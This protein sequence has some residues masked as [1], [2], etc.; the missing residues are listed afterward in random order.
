MSWT[1]DVSGSIPNAMLEWFDGLTINKKTY[2]II[3]T[4]QRRVTPAELLTDC[5]DTVAD[6]LSEESGVR[7]PGWPRPTDLDD[8]A[9]D[10]VFGALNKVGLDLI[11]PRFL[12]V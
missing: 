2:T 3:A 4:D 6:Q 8:R 10:E 12:H 5:R 9:R 11:R 7:V 1:L